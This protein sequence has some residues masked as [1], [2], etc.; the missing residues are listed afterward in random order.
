MSSSSGSVNKQSATT[1]PPS[2]H[3]ASC[4]SPDR[5]VETSRRFSFVKKLN[6]FGTSSTSSV[7]RKI[8]RRETVDPTTSSE[9]RTDVKSLKQFWNNHIL[10]VQSAT[11][12]QKSSTLSY[13][14]TNN[15]N[16]SVIDHVEKSRSL[17]RCAKF[18]SVPSL[19]EERTRNSFSN[20]VSEIKSTSTSNLSEVPDNFDKFKT[21]ETVKSRRRSSKEEPNFPLVAT[22]GGTKIHWVK[23][24]E[25]FRPKEKMDKFKIYED[26]PS[27]DSIMVSD[28]VDMVVESPKTE[29]DKTPRKVSFRTK[30]PT[31]SYHRRIKANNSSRV[32][33]LTLRFNQLVQQDENLLNEVKKNGG[34]VHKVGNHVYK[35][36]EENSLKKKEEDTA[37]TSSR[38]SSSK[39]KS[40]VRRKASMK[41]KQKESSVRDLKD[42]FEPTV[43]P[44]VPDKSE[45]VLQRSTELRIIKQL[46]NAQDLSETL[47]PK[48]H[49]I[50][51]D[52]DHKSKY[53]RMYEKLKFRSLFAANKKLSSSKDDL[54][55]NPSPPASP[56]PPENETEVPVDTEPDVLPEP[57]KH[58]TS[59]IHSLRAENADDS[60]SDEK[61][62]EEIVSEY[63]LLEAL[64]TIDNRIESLKAKE[65][66]QPNTSF[67]FSTLPK[68][69]STCDVQSSLV[70]AINEALNKT[71]SMDESLFPHES[72]SNILL[73]TIKVAQNSNEAINEASGYEYIRKPEEKEEVYQTLAEAY[74]EKPKRDSINS[75]ESFEQY[76]SLDEYHKEKE[77]EYETCE[78]PPEPPPPRKPSEP[79]LPAPKRNIPDFTPNY[80][81]VKYND[82]PP[83]PPKDHLELPV[84]EPVEA[85]EVSQEYYE[86][87]I[88][89]TI[90]N[91]NQ[92]LLSSC[93]EAIQQR[94]KLNGENLIYESLISKTEFQRFNYLQHADSIL[95]LASDQKTNSIYG[96]TIG[97]R[98][99]L[100]SERSSDGSDEWIDMSDD[101]EKHKFIV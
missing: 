44:K 33:A 4:T 31:N 77:Y 53:S 35:I 8:E 58:E 14:T 89:D 30:T 37:S 22:T 91:D 94:N 80:E 96:T 17:E 69:T 23:R 40:S 59:F 63:R 87:N 65:N 16:D 79:L 71:Q 10:N 7:A 27:K 101:D 38:V 62:D 66:M 13:R 83:R 72:S 18:N 85:E 52:P 20:S 21:A 67:L 12:K 68:S 92:S 39:K 43:K 5:T 29:S 75:Y 19:S 88:Y 56:C 57:I 42:L 9:Y 86:E 49:F 93:Y 60:N 61:N 100:P 26:G 95:T 46:P 28:M 82:V 76:E 32:A 15:N 45:T 48:E 97:H 99:S 74:T 6:L 90:K 54:D 11:V 25:L 55:S 70:I 64:T 51:K 24:D 2:S 36:V 47:R 1:T 78:S 50:K 73:T 81:S 3:H 98:N 84:Q 34:L 41:S